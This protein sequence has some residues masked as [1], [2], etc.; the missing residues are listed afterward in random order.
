MAQNLLSIGLCTRI[1][2]D[3]EVSNLKKHI[4]RR[5]TSKTIKYY[6]QRN[7][8]LDMDCRYKKQILLKVNTITSIG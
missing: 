6:M 4:L 3:S 8:R 1:C 2:Q 5:W 7:S